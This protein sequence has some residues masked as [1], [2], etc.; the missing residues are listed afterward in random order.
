M[1]KQRLPRSVDGINVLVYVVIR[2]D[3]QFNSA[4]VDFIRREKARHELEEELFVCF[5]PYVGTV[6]DRVPKRSG[7]VQVLVDFSDDCTPSLVPAVYEYLFKF[8]EF[9]GRLKLAD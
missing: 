3:E 8:L 5:V 6:S 7:L 4:W 9:G 1:L 2:D